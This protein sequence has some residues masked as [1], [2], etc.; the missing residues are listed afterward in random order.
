MKFKICRPRVQS[1]QHVNPN[2]VVSV[3]GTLQWFAMMIYKW[4]NGINVSR[5]RSEQF[6]PGSSLVEWT[7]DTRVTG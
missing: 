6:S 7:T 4:Y 2:V 5:G 1:R 3:G